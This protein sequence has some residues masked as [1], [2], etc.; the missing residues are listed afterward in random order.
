MA[1]NTTSTSS[2]GPVLCKNC[3]WAHLIQ[4]DQNPILAECTK[5]P[6]PGN[7]R[8]PYKVEVACVERYCN[9]YKLD[10]EPKEIEHRTHHK[11]SSAA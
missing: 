5:N 7:T 6:Q 4:Y 9:I 3:K 11:K 2:K 10:P 1:S 8:F